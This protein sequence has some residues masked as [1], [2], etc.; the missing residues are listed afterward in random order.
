M[1]LT[2]LKNKFLI[3]GSLVLSLSLLS[4]VGTYAFFNAQTAN[5]NNTVT[6]GTISITSNRDSS[7]PIDGP[8][9]YTTP[10]DG[11]VVSGDN[12]GLLGIYKDGFIKPGW[13]SK[14]KTLIVTNKGTINPKLTKIGAQFVEGDS[15]LAGVLQAVVYRVNAPG[16]PPTQLYSGSLQS[17]LTA[18]QSISEIDIDGKNT[19][20]TLGFQVIFPE[21]HTDQNAYQGKRL[22]VDFI[23][24]A[25]PQ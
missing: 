24:Y 13:E 1:G 15:D 14:I 10:E 3:A 16:A 7:D 5:T 6:A 19:Q 18:P 4:G 20:E 11:K 23:V 22:K 8:M 17:L 2:L 9:F 21:N 25:D 12:A